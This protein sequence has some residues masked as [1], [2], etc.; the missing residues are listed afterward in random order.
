MK[1]LEQVLEEEYSLSKEQFSE[2]EDWYRFTIKDCLFQ[3]GIKEK[4]DQDNLYLV[5]HLDKI[6]PEEDLDKVLTMAENAASNV[7]DALG[8]YYELTNLDGFFAF[9]R[10]LP[11]TPMFG[12][13]PSAEEVVKEIETMVTFAKHSAVQAVNR[14]YRSR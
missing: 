4:F 8:I 12:T 2:G 11:L 14:T 1:L 9:D 6:D 5:V 13:P 3:G 7:K 10:Y